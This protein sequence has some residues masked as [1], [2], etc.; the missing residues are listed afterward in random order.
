VR[1]AALTLEKCLLR[2]SSLGDKHR[3]IPRKEEHESN[4]GRKSKQK[5][6]GELSILGHTTS[7]GE[8]M[9]KWSIS[10]L[11]CKGWGAELCLVP[12]LQ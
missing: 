4:R 7:C 10:E 6:S 9:E 11:S 1:Q 2:A 3:E 12:K 5:L 8:T